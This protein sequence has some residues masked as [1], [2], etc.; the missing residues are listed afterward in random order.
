MSSQLPDNS[1]QEKTAM[2]AQ[3]T[4]GKKH[5]IKRYAELLTVASLTVPEEAGSSGLSGSVGLKTTKQEA[6]SCSVS[7][8][9]H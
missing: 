3:Q 5:L 2:Q 1:V 4:K 6:T 9:G 7:S 8:A